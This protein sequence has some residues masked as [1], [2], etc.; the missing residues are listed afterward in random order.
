MSEEHKHQNWHKLPIF[1][2]WREAMILNNQ[3]LQI[4]RQV[5][6][7]DRVFR[8]LRRKEQPNLKKT[9]KKYPFREPL[10]S[11]LRQLYKQTVKDI[12]RVLGVRHNPWVMVPPCA[13]AYKLEAPAV[14]IIDRHEIVIARVFHYWFAQIDLFLPRLSQAMLWSLKGKEQ[15]IQWIDLGKR[16][17]RNSLYYK[18]QLEELEVNG[19]FQALS[20]V[21]S[22]FIQKLPPFLEET[23]RLGSPSEALF[24]WYELLV[25]FRRDLQSFLR[26][27]LVHELI[28][29]HTRWVFYRDG[30]FAHRQLGLLNWRA[31]AV[32]DVQ[33]E[34]SLTHLALNEALTE[35]IAIRFRQ[36]LYQASGDFHWNGIHCA[37]PYPAWIIEAVVQTLDR[38]WQRLAD[39]LPSLAQHQIFNTTD[40][41]YTFYFSDATKVSYFKE[42][43]ILLSRDQEAFEKLSIGCEHFYYFAH[44][45]QPRDEEEFKVSMLEMCQMFDPFFEQEMFAAFSPSASD[46]QLLREE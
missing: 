11:S 46:G 29:A 23:E 7:E 10:S 30:E 8:A 38:E 4:R 9:I 28:H 43:L 12:G 14:Y 15:H 41:L 33:V 40:L 13:F 35:W 16:L 31:K 26:S 5:R 32:P 21:W 19:L 22:Q 27:T 37:S 44:Y 20:D 36:Q 34:A 42:A 45:H 39:A 2:K 6:K 17:M 18:E 25:A 1:E 24:S 3:L